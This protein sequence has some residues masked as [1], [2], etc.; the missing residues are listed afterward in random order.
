MLMRIV[1]GRFSSNA[2]LIVLVITSH[3]TEGEGGGVVVVD[4]DVVDVVAHLYLPA[5]ARQQAARPG[6]APRSAAST[7]TNRSNR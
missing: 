5:V 6:P 1:P 4:Q 2:Y 3:T 7:S